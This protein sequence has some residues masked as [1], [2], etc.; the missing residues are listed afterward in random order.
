MLN[1]RAAYWFVPL[2]LLRLISSAPLYILDVKVMFLHWQFS[3]RWIRIIIVLFHEGLKSPSYFLSKAHKDTWKDTGCLPLHTG[4]YH[5][6]D[7]MYENGLVVFCCC[8]CCLLFVFFLSKVV[9]PLRHHK[10]FQPCKT[11][12]K[13]FSSPLINY[14]PAVQWS[15]Q[16]TLEYIKASLLGSWSS[17][18]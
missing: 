16:T 11:F 13:I 9:C 5:T 12:I 6:L 3:N 10:P 17:T 15:T 18:S 4:N 7:G 8:C 2:S 14:S 1:R